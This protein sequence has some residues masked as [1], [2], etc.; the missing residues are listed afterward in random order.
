MAD[1]ADVLRV[2]D[3]GLRGGDVVGERGVS[4]ARRVEAVVECDTEAADRGVQL[5][6]H[7]DRVVD[8]RVVRRADAV[9]LVEHDGDLHGS[10]ARHDHL[11]GGRTGRG[12]GRQQQGSEGGDEE[13]SRDRHSQR[14]GT[15][16]PSVGEGFSCHFRPP[17][18]AA[19][20]ATM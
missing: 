11:T 2:G 19:T 17:A 10:P 6:G 18:V 8:P 9:G 20:T 16:R 5:H 7:A 3:D 14:C 1:H 4:D 12:R 15:A 13:R